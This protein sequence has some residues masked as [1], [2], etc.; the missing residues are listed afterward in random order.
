MR[1]AMGFCG[2]LAKATLSS[3]SIKKLEV[4]NHTEVRR[5]MVALCRCRKAESS[6]PTGFD[7]FL[8]EGLMLCEHQ[9]GNVASLSVIEMFPL[10][11]KDEYHQYHFCISNC[12]AFAAHLGSFSQL[13]TFFLCFQRT[14]SGCEAGV[15]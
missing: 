10:M 8:W 2:Q 5:Y 4:G 14:G 11:I 9:A 1:L 6:S 15:C 12:V 3:L 13:L 7:L